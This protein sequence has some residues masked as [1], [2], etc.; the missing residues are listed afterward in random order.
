MQAIKRGGWHIAR[1]KYYEQF[2]GA[3]LFAAEQKPEGEEEGEAESGAPGEAHEEGEDLAEK[4]VEAATAAEQPQQ[5]AQQQQ[6]QP[7][8]YKT[9]ML[10]AL[11][12]QGSMPVFDAM[13]RNM[14]SN[15][16]DE[17]SKQQHTTA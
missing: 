3:P 5:A 6:Q 2:A 9:G 11:I 4:G 7:G 16:P 12:K 15:H 17:V 14:H 10:D 8:A 13:R 1:N